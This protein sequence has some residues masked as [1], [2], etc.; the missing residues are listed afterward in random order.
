MEVI[1]VEPRHSIIPTK[2]QVVVP[3]GSQGRVIRL[4]DSKAK[5]MLLLPGT[6]DEWMDYWRRGRYSIPVT[7]LDREKGVIMRRHRIG[8]M[9]ERI[10]DNTWEHEIYLLEK[11]PEDSQSLKEEKQ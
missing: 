11:L 8:A 7:W 1:F 10:L 2:D 3:A 6:L 4:K 9:P 5:D